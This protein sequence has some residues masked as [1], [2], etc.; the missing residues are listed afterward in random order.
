MRE[1]GADSRTHPRSKSSKTNSAKDKEALT[2]SDILWSVDQI[3]KGSGDTRDN[4]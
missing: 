1:E 4:K 2:Q 3:R